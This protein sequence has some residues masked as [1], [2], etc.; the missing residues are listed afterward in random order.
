[1]ATGNVITLAAQ[2]TLLEELPVGTTVDIKIVKE[3]LINIPFPCVEIEGQ[4][5]GSW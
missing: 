4:M 1:M 2:I 5:V 3:G